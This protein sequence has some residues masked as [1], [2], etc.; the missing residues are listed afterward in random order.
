MKAVKG[1]SLNEQD[2][3]AALEAVFPKDGQTSFFN[4]ARG[5]F[6]YLKEIKFGANRDQQ[7]IGDKDHGKATKNSQDDESM[8]KK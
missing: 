5:A 4:K 2:A 8:K 1:N 3:L 7:A 6:N